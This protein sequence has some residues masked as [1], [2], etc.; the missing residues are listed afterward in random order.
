VLADAMQ[1]NQ[2]IVNHAPTPGM[3]WMISRRIDQS[4]AYLD[5]TAAGRLAGMRRGEGRASV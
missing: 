5:A 2:V 4:I 3:R 1:V